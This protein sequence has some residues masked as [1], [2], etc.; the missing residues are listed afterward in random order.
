MFSKCTFSSIIQ[1][2][3]GSAEQKQIHNRC[4]WI[5]LNRPLSFQQWTVGNS[6]G[7]IIQWVLYLPIPKSHLTGSQSSPSQCPY[8][9]R[10]ENWIVLTRF[11]S[12][13]VHFAPAHLHCLHTV[14]LFDPVLLFDWLGFLVLVCLFGISC[15]VLFCGFLLLLWVCWFGFWF[16]FFWWGFLFVWGGF[17]C[18]FYWV[19]LRGDLTVNSSWLFS[20]VLILKRGKCRRSSHR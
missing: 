2:I 19:F 4:P 15:F 16:W 20:P 7:I 8:P 3:N 10:E 9:V 1:I 5:S 13:Y 12:W 14:R 6:L 18:L 17:V 11:C